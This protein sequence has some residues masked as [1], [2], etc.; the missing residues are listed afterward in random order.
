MKRANLPVPLV[1]ALDEA[2]CKIKTD[3]KSAWKFGQNKFALTQTHLCQMKVKWSHKC[4]DSINI[5]I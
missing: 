3:S 2:V 1:A 5:I 4:T